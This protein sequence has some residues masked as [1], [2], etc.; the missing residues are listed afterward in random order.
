[1]GKE[2]VGNGN[3]LF[4]YM[5]DPESEY[6]GYYYYDSALN[7]TSY[8]RSS[9]RFYVYEYLERT[10][11]HSA[12]ESDFLPLNS[13]Y[14]NTNGLTVS[15]DSDGT[16]VYEAKASANNV[17]TNYHFGMKTNIH[18]YLPNDT[19]QAVDDYGNMGNMDTNGNPMIFYFNGDDDLWVFVDGKLVLDIGGIHGARSGTIDFST[20]QVYND[21]NLSHSISLTEGGHDLTIY[22]LERGSSLSNCAIYF[23]LAPRYGLELEKQDFLT[24][25]AVNGVVFSVYTDAACTE[26]AKLWNSHLDAKEDKPST[27]HFT[28]QD[29][30]LYMW[31]LVAGK[32][33][34][35]VENGEL[36]PDAVKQVYQISDDLLRVTLNDHGTDVSEMTILRGNDGVRTSGF[37]IVAHTLNEETQTVHVTVTNPRIPDETSTSKKVKVFKRWADGSSNLP[38]TITLR[39]MANGEQFGS[40]VNLSGDNGWVYTWSG[41]PSE[42]ANGP[43]IYEVE[44][45][46]VPGFHSNVAERVTTEDI[47]DWL[48]V[49]AL[50]DGETYMILTGSNAIALSNGALTTVSQ[51]Q[52]KEDPAAQWKVV[53]NNDG[54]R[55]FNGSYTLTL[56]GGSNYIVT[57]GTGNQ[58]LYF[59]GTRLFAMYNQNRYFLGSVSG[60]KAAASTTAQT[61]QLYKHELTTRDVQ[62]FIVENTPIPKDQQ[63]SLTVN[64]VWE[65]QNNILGINVVVRLFA[66]GEDTGRTVT[67]NRANKWTAAFTGLDKTVTYSVREEIIPGYTPSYSEMTPVTAI[68]VQWQTQSSLVA[69]NVYCFTANGRALTDNGSTITATTVNLDNIADNQQWE[70]VKNGNYIRLRNVDTGRYLRV[71]Y[72]GVSGSTAS[73]ATNATLQN[74]LLNMNGRYLQLNSN[75]VTST[76]RTSSATTFVTYKETE[77]QINAGYQVTITNTYSGAELPKTG[78]IGTPMLYTFGAVFLIAAALMYRYPFGQR[79]RGEGGKP[80]GS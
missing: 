40:N 51:E 70:A 9:Q 24:R 37:E 20:G 58:T 41:L 52:A 2:K 69:G 22:Y 13:P 42:D 39:L 47:T 45:L 6:Y 46:A 33:Y 63:I 3:Y 35:I 7:A 16:Y 29:G 21:G 23:N 62:Q 32:T 54:Y 60:G 59:D 78:G 61:V 1:M 34:Y 11:D 27:N 15:Q 10:S 56:D 76:T 17:T 19:G 48:K 66:D 55:I 31:G 44:E 75:S 38:K 28:V 8:N 79:K 80:P 68:D 64:K 4:Q 43:I 14:A 71:G 65:T 73:N 25:E 67:L 57:T 77:V 18:F 74:G 12:G 5:N 50:E 49:G 72:T 53:A 36:T 26:P 30:Y